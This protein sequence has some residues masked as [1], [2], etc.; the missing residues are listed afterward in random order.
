M[1]ILL[2]AASGVPIYE[3]IKTQIR[4]AI[5][6]GEVPE[7]SLLTSL[8][9]LSAQLRVSLITVT[10]AYNDLV[11]EG[12]VA[13][14]HGRGFVVRPVDGAVASAALAERVERGVA[15]VVSAGRSARMTVGEVTRM[16]EEQ[17]RKHG[18]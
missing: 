12:L 18:G 3:Q 16:V 17:W 1:Q 13:N 2:S 5:H 8:R 11:A 6:S 9:Q 15:E 7:G 14:E 4:A 10:R